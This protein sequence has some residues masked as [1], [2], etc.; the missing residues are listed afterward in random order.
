[1]GQ[2]LNRLDRSIVA[3]KHWIFVINDTDKEFQRRMGDKKW[4]IFHY[5]GNRKQIHSGDKVIFYKAGI[6]GK[7]LLGT[8][9]ISSELLNDENQQDYFVALDEIKVWKK[10]VKIKNLVD[11]LEFIGDKV[12]W[13]RYLQGGI[14][15]ISENDYGIIVSK[16]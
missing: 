2:F 3:M 12:Q 15:E 7:T 13:G 14:R 9:K 6:E 10:P 16:S 1:M 4:P 8:A 11:S 5:T